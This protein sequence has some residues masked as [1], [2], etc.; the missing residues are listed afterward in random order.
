M[1][2]EACRMNLYPIC[3]KRP[4]CSIINNECLGL[5]A[6]QAL[7]EVILAIVY[8]CDLISKRGQFSSSQGIRMM[9]FP[10]T[11]AI[12]SVIGTLADTMY[13]NISS[14]A[15][16]HITPTMTY[17][18]MTCLRRRSVT[19]VITPDCIVFANTMAKF[20]Q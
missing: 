8:G 12:L 1:A 3:N 2:C 4:P 15:Q 10:R 19:K 11:V 14:I 9:T 6:E 17:I 18:L 5:G 16:A 13:F 20:A 7:G